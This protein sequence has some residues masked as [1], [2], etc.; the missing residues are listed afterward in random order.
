M[1]SSAK[2]AAWS[3]RSI[4]CA[5][6]NPLS[7]IF[8]TTTFLGDFFIDPLYKSHLVDKSGS[9][10]LSKTISPTVSVSSVS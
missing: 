10:D 7:S 5:L 3:S 1:S 4:S 8:F 6:S 2:E 9:G